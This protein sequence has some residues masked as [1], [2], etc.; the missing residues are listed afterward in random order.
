MHADGRA[1]W[2]IPS[3]GAGV[4]GAGV[5][6]RPSR[7]APES[8]RITV[9]RALWPRHRR[10]APRAAPRRSPARE[11]SVPTHRRGVRGRQLHVW[12]GV[13][14]IHRHLVG[15]AT[16]GASWLSMS[17]ATACGSTLKAQAAEHPSTRCR[18]R[19][20][21]PSDRRAQAGSRARTRRVSPHAPEYGGTLTTSD[22]R[23][24]PGDHPISL[25][26]I[27]LV[28]DPQRSERRRGG[29]PGG[30]T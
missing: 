12:T 8:G 27:I 2:A 20:R 11:P 9:G 14:R 13:R 28:R 15:A 19:V 21:Q 26:A 4:G 29:G 23:P 10:S 30:H 22:V 25:F 1:A 17:C 7:G 3:V 16:P 6:A 24:D 18:V 5:G